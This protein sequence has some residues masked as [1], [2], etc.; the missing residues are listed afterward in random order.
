MFIVVLPGARG[1]STKVE[2]CK[3][4]WQS[5]T[6]DKGVMKQSYFTTLTPAHRMQDEPDDVAH[7]LLV[8]SS[9]GMRQART[10]VRLV[11]ASSESVLVTG[12]T[13]S[14]KDLVARAI[15][16]LSDLRAGP[17]VAVNCGAIPGDLIDS[18]LFGHERGAF[19]GATERRVGRFEQASGGTLFLDEIGDMPLFAQTRLLRVLENRSFER[20]GGKVTLPFMGRV[21]AATHKNIHDAATTGHFRHDLLHRLATLSI[22]MPPLA[23]RKEDIPQLLTHLCAGMAHPPQFTASAIEMLCTHNWP[24]NVREL[25]SV[26]SRAAVLYHG[27]SIETEHIPYLISGNFQPVATKNATQDA[28]LRALLNSVEIRSLRRA[29]HDHNGIV[30][31]AA[32]SMGIKRTTFI[33]KM[34]RLGIQRPPIPFAE[35]TF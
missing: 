3:S 12:P 22:T 2:E 8:G 27:T 25:R 16:G 1:Q 18:E 17:L 9:D 28:D 13:G 4:R 14:G 31:A 6:A 15:H 26:I 20:V 23:L 24:G 34:R 32:R 35:A 11:A 29:L 19:T 33:A 21:I 10:L 5:F 7:R 30:A